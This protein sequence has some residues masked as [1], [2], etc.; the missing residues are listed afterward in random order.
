MRKSVHGQTT[1]WHTKNRR[2]GRWNFWLVVHRHDYAMHPSRWVIQ[3][4]VT[5]DCKR[6]PKAKFPHGVH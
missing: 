3:P 2:L 5:Y 4:Y 1:T 6:K